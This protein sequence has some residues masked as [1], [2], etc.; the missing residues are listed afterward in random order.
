VIVAED[1]GPVARRLGGP[2]VATLASRRRAG[3]TKEGHREG[4]TEDAGDARLHGRDAPAKRFWMPRNCGRAGKKVI[5][6]PTVTSWRC[7]R[8]FPR[9]SAAAVPGDPLGY[10]VPFD[11][12]QNRNPAPPILFLIRK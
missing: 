3:E 5:P 4:Q 12:K 8:S 10:A 7:T 6:P 1:R 2:T 9:P 11:L